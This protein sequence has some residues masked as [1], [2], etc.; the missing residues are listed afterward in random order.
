MLPVGPAPYVCGRVSG[1]PDFAT[2]G[3]GISAF[4]AAEDVLGGAERAELCDQGAEASPTKVTWSSASRVG[5]ALMTLTRVRPAY[6]LVVGDPDA[7]AEL[8]KE[9]RQHSTS[10]ST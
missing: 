9:R 4:W 3:E 7:A 5:A 6:V 1:C 2:D 8:A 10:T